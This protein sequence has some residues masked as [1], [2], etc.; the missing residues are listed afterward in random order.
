MLLHQTKEKLA[1]MKLSGLLS[2]LDE[3][4]ASEG[5]RELSFEERLGMLVD[6]EYLLRENRR[7]TRRFQ[8]ARLKLRAQV[9]DVDFQAKRGLDREFFLHLAGGDWI[10]QRHNLI[11]TG[12]TGC[13]K[14]YLACALAHKACRDG[15]RCL[16]YHFPTLVRELR[17]SQAEG[18][19][20]EF[21]RKLAKRDLLIIDDWLW[22]PLSAEQARCLV[23][24]FE[25][26]FRSRSTLLTS[27]LPVSEWHD[28]F[29]DPT[30][31][32]AVL[33]RIIHDSHRIEL[34]GDS[35]RKQTAKLTKRAE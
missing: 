7:L 12:A 2:G 5:Y 14:T 1:E 3:Q 11:M 29:Q 18:R 23:E 25:D 32:D 28:R 6:R 16:Y 9:E 33:D 19:S 8:E 34:K 13:G 27:Q 4:L 15:F 22:E 10:R 20:Q 21:T 26:R 35:M 24:L 17:I 30:L 31:A